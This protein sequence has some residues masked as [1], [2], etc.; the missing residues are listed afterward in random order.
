MSHFFQIGEHG[1]FGKETDW[2]VVPRL[3]IGLGGTG[4][5]VLL[6]F[7]RLLVER[8]GSL[9]ALP[10][11][12][13]LHLDTDQT[14][15]ARTQY[16]I[17]ADDDPLYDRIKFRKSESLELKIDGGTGRY[18]TNMRAYPH[19]KKWFPT[20][21]ELA[22]LGDLGDGAA[23]VRIASRLGFFHAPN[24]GNI[25]TALDRARVELTD[26]EIQRKIR[27]YGFSFDADSMEIYIIASTAGGTGGG[28]FIDM[29]YLVKSMFP[30]AERVGLLFMP[31]IFANYTGYPRMQ[32]NGYA[33]LMELNHYSLGNNFHTQWEP[34]SVEALP[35][36][37][38]SYT[39]LIDGKND[40]GF[41][42]GGGGKEYSLYQMA[43]ETLFQTYWAGTFAA[44]KRAVRINL[45]SFLLSTYAHNFWDITTVSGEGTGQGI[46]GDTYPNRYGS[47]GTGMISF[48]ADRVHSACACRLAEQILE[49]WQSNILEDAMDSLVKEFLVHPDISFMQGRYTPKG[50][51]PVDRLDIEKSLLW[52][53]AGSSRDFY[54]HLHEKTQDLAR[55][56]Q[57]T[58][59]GEK[60]A[61][62]ERYI[63]EF[64]QMMGKE[65]SEHEDEWGPYARTLE[66]NMNRYLKQ[67][68][69]GIMER[70]GVF[71]DDS[72]YGIAYVLSVMQELKRV[73]QKGEEGDI[74]LYR[75]YFEGNIGP[76]VENIQYY[77]GQLQELVAD[78]RRHERQFL[79]KK[80]DVERD[81]EILIGTRE[82]PGC[83]FNFMYSRIMKQVVTRGKQICESIDRFLGKDDSTGTGFLA[84]YHN[85]VGGFGVLRE[86][87]KKFE[88]YFT[89]EKP[90]EFVNSV[91]QPSDVDE[92][93]ARWIDEAEQERKNRT[94]VANRL[95][96]DVFNV[97]SVAEALA[98]LQATHEEDI[99]AKVI[100]TCKVF[101]AT[102][103]QQPSALEILMGAGRFGPKEQMDLVKHAYDMAKV[104][105]DGAHSGLSHIN[106][107]KP[108]ADQ[109]PFYI[110][111][112]DSS[113][114]LVKE[115]EKLIKQIQKP[116][117][118]PLQRVPIGEKN[119]S[120]IVFY[121]EIA[122]VPAFYSDSVVCVGGLKEAYDKHYSKPIGIEEVHTDKNRFRF[123]HI[124]PRKDTDVF[125]YVESVKAF[126]LARILGLLH[127]E[128]VNGDARSP[129]F[130]FYYTHR[131]IY[132]TEECR[133][134]DELHAVDFLS[135]NRE[136]R[137]MM[138]EDIQ[139]V[140]NSLR[141][142][143][144]LAYY[145]LLIEFYIKHVYRRGV[146]DEVTRIVR[147]SPQYGLLEFERKQ[148]FS[149]IV[150]DET[151]KHKLVNALSALRGKPVG[152]NLGYHGFLSILHPFCR[153]S[154]KY[155]SEES[156]AAGN[157]RVV[158]LDAYAL[159]MR[160]LEAI[161][162]I[163]EDTGIQEEGP[164]E[165]PTAAA[166]PCPSCS[167]EIN[168]KT[169]YCKHCKQVVSKHMT[170]PHCREEKVPED[171]DI[172]WKCDRPLH[173]EES[174][175]ECPFCGTLNRQKRTT[176]RECGAPFGA[177]LPAVTAP[178]EPQQEEEKEEENIEP[179]ENPEP[180]EP[181][182]LTEP[183]TQLELPM[184]KENAALPPGEDEPTDNDEWEES[185]G[186]T[187]FTP[188]Q[189]LECPACTSLVARTPNCEICGAPL[190]Y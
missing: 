149:N 134:G 50:E 80:Q 114:I 138:L 69:K 103:P 52:F 131:K 159:D 109:K 53:D 132:D 101:F 93:Y 95:L 148:I 141:D 46:Y 129:E 184:E 128:A 16:D 62:L 175:R 67:V 90:Y 44:R 151:E 59:F 154:G 136:L 126:V 51:E 79:H 137:A 145:L 81:M 9:E 12:R 55:E 123:S 112:D 28:T 135:R 11:I 3:I 130:I 94:Q 60:S 70:A 177:D 133:L 6:R 42:L 183:G 147:Y 167:T 185:E 155:A 121:N 2:P 38:F 173:I 41:T 156:G 78:F 139:Q 58:R 85:L 88:A 49:E 105:L 111:I 188:E 176:C 45:S 98:Y 5:E 158:Y 24:F 37:P 82:E 107:S 25:K 23:Q 4:K 21:G 125:R 164:K 157:A 43:A 91:Y 14:A 117:D 171:L 116:Q 1:K 27:D 169:T 63:Q 160:K 122:G 92:W 47:M 178:K 113:P 86:R 20:K 31:A 166:R 18:I 61:V 104:W 115:F 56:L 189:S 10:F 32:A 152:E 150:V 119:K 100:E 146:E 15:T 120:V 72:R 36:P 153:L 87:L 89:V 179:Q 34:V 143:R 142:R 64:Q 172:C 108:L 162:R 68:E 35:P 170:C 127:A 186:E 73:L 54:H 57:N 190:K 102:H 74:F 7:R 30:D 140:F 106:Y 180:T 26:P 187:I 22:D 110:G 168:V 84:R 163:D 96:K 182:T 13:Y 66:G 97:D 118:P 76:W 48:P 19:I 144:L 181:T 77:D 40:A 39:Y 33:S 161:A 17:N 29:A 71:A 65:D 124:V 8:F 83:F 99:V 174:K 165:A 75:K